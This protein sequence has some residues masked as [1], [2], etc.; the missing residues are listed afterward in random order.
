MRGKKCP[1]V[2][3]VACMY[4]CLKYTTLPYAYRTPTVGMTMSSKCFFAV[5]GAAV[6]V[7]VTVTVI[8]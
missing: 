8:L 1:G 4:R 5:V 7:T 2:L 3:D 6:T